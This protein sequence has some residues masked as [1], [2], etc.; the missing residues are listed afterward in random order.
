MTKSNLAISKYYPGFVKKA[1]SFTIDD[2]NYKL[3]KKFIDI[4]R[5][6]GITGAFNLCGDDAKPVGMTDEEYREFYQGYEITNHAHRH[7]KLLIDK[8]EVVVTDAPVD[9]K[10]AESTDKNLLFK[11]EIEG[12]YLRSFGRYFGRVTDEDTYIWL[13]DEGKRQLDKIFGAENI[14]A[15]VWPYCEQPS[16][17]IKAHLKS[18][19]YK[20]VRKT[21]LSDF[22]IPKDKMAWIYNAHHANLTERAAEYEKLDTDELTF[23]CF[24]IH[25]HDYEN[26]NCWD[27]LEKFAQDFGNR[28]DFYYATPTEIFDYADAA[29]SL[30][31]SESKIENPSDIDIYLT[32]NGKKTVV[33][34]RAHVDV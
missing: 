15:F 20:S 13:V 28:Q 29:D 1:I 8:D 5:P 32:V 12:M 2:G 31:V 6:A 4:V 14:T 11:S 21:G 19:G 17:K 27:V 24:G 33:P 25:S 9:L 7:P 23:F 26:N 3:D 22:N 10:K 18:A 30:I 16:D 34:A